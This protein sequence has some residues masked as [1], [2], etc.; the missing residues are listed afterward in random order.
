[1][2]DD[3]RNSAADQSGFNDDSDADL[4]PLLSKKPQPV[5]RK[6]GGRLLGMTAFQRFMI[7]VLLFLLVCILGA[8]AVMLNSSALM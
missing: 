5:R 3:L 2:F 4:E 1:M 8:M 7:S 6:R